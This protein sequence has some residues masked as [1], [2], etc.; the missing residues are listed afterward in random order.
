M[1]NVKSLQKSR[2]AAPVAVPKGLSKGAQDY[3][4]MIVGHL[5]E[6]GNWQEVDAR[7]VE[8][9]V[10]THEAILEE[11]ARLAKEG[12]VVESDQGPKKHPSCTILHELHAQYRGMASALGL[13]AAAR[14]RLQIEI[15]EKVENPWQRKA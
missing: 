9:L 1:S 2:T 6:S 10:R 15:A 11:D 13:G 8:M 4:R 3:Y 14:R 7:M 5:Q 12:R